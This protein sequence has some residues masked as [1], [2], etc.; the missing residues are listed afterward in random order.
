MALTSETT[1]DLVSFAAAIKQYYRRI[2]FQKEIYKKF[3][4][5]GI[6]PKD[7][8][9]VGSPLKQPLAFATVPSRSANFATAQAA[10][11]SSQQ[12]AFLVTTVKDY[13]L[14]Y[15]DR[16]TMLASKSDDG[17]WLKAA[18]H[19][20]DMAIKEVTKS[21]AAALFLDGS[22][23]IGAVASNSTVT[24]TTIQLTDARQAVNFQVNDVL[25]AIPQ[26]S[27]ILNTYASAVRS[28]TVTLN[29]VNRA[30]GVL[31]ATGNWNSGIS[32]IQTGDYLCKNGDFNNKL[33]GLSAWMPIGGVTNTSD[34]FFG[35]NRSSDSRLAGSYTDGRG[36]P[37]EEAIILGAANCA[38]EG[39]APDLV[40]L[41]YRNWVNVINDLGSKKIYFREGKVQADGADVGYDAVEFEGP[42]GPMRMVADPFCPSNVVYALETDTW[43]LHTRGELPHIFD[44]DGEAGKMLRQATADAYEVRTGYYGNAV[45]NAP[46]FNSVIQVS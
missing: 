21:A 17:A 40:L 9:F 26:G 37:L 46:I 43:C 44:I 2:D 4:W 42:A 45:C 36:M 19:E 15:I 24:G 30:T 8:E 12:A 7:T 20:I 25:Q 27:A 22:G 33:S 32:A 31:T 23:A 6:I 13:G 35:V 1:L 10:A 16:E 38:Q 11:G 34:S 39:G 28:G 29:G 14:A 41:N 3:P 5:L 18:T